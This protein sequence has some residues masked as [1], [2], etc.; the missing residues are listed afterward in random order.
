MLCVGDVLRLRLR[1]VLRVDLRRVVRLLLRTGR[2]LPLPLLPGAVRGW[3]HR[4]RFQRGEEPVRILPRL[5]WLL[6]FAVLGSTACGATPAV[7]THDRPMR[8][9]VGIGH[10]QA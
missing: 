5:I 4:A 6:H 9:G 7:C 2:C 1:V 3:V 8:A 10:R